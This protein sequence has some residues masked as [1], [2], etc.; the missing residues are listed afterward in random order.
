[1]Q[2]T[3]PICIVFKEDTL[4]PFDV[5][6]LLRVRGN[7]PPRLHSS[8]ANWLIGYVSTR[9]GLFGTAIPAA[10]RVVHTRPPASPQGRRDGG[11]WKV[12]TDDTIDPTCVVAWAPLCPTGVTRA[13][14]CLDAGAEVWPQRHAIA[15][16]DWQGQGPPH[17]V[18]VDPATPAIQAAPWT[19]KPGEYVVLTPDA[20]RR[21]G[22]DFDVYEILSL[23][24]LEATVRRT[25]TTTHVT[26]A[27]RDLAPW[28]PFMVGELVKFR[29]D[30]ARRKYSLTTDTL[31]RVAEEAS[32]RIGLV[33][34]HTL[35]EPLRAEVRVFSVDLMRP[36]GPVSFPGSDFADAPGPDSMHGAGD[37][38]SGSDFDD[39]SPF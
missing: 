8:T 28:V 19:A 38:A 20:Q 21:L 5:P 27:I 29:S 13:Q 14:E 6:V 4:P 11:P 3:D 15:R 10:I 16:R 37:D 36:L 1:M 18:A 24:P 39:G 22:C 25:S 35:S 30:A 26:F 7:A 33:R 34:V 2:L 32:D 17:R 12:V 9:P 31:M 23:T